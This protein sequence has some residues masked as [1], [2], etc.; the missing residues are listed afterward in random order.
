MSI[1][2]G[3]LTV[4]EYEGQLRWRGVS[5]YEWNYY[6]AC[7]THNE[8]LGWVSVNTRDLDAIAATSPRAYTVQLSA[9][10]TKTAELL[11]RCI[12]CLRAEMH[13]RQARRAKD[14]RR[15][16]AL[17][18]TPHRAWKYLRRAYPLMI[19]L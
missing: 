18:L 9:A 19:N 16:R 17:G 10:L 7:A 6:L 5:A 14:Y 4:L 8:P 13:Q 1:H 12:H 3:G 2:T 11:T 15:L